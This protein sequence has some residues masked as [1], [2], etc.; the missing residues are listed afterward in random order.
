MS[1]SSEK[2]YYQ[3][4]GLTPKVTQQAIEDRFRALARL[5]HPDIGGDEGE[6]SMVA[7]AAAVLRDF[8]MR[9]AYDCELIFTRGICKT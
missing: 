8:G 2:T 7:E 3:I 9:R 6:F 1:K 4:L 5:H